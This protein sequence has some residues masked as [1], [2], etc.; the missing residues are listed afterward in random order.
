M[1]VIYDQFGIPRKISHIRAVE[2]LEKLKKESGSNP[3]P[4][5]KECFKVWSATG[6]KKWDS[7]LVYLQGVKDSRKETVVG[8]KRWRGVSKDNEQGGLVSY[9]I[10]MPEPVNRMIR[11][12]YSP[13]E[14]PMNKEFF[15]EFGKRF[16][17]MRV[18]EARN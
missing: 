5:I 15:E 11:A 10:D 17:S 13:E 1:D 7:Y 9:T 6:P 14:L 2:R 16:P 12:I 4:V 18:R 3:W 8:N